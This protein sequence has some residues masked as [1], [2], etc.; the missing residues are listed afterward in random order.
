[1][2]R[3]YLF[4]LVEG[5][6]Y[7]VWPPFAAEAAAHGFE[8]SFAHAQLLTRDFLFEL[9]VLLELRECRRL[10]GLLIRALDDG[11]LLGCEAGARSRSVVDVRRSA[12]QSHQVAAAVLSLLQRDWEHNRTPQ[13]FH[14]G[15]FHL[16][17]GMR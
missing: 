11:C 1:M 6:K 15:A 2:S 17:V 9:V 14:A 8:S 16:R 5:D 4:S 12:H 10:G 13:A 7:S 3:F